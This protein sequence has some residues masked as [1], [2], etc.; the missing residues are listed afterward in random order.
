MWAAGKAIL[1]AEVA[2]EAHLGEK[3][4]HFSL[5]ALVFEPWEGVLL[6]LEFPPFAPLPGSL[7]WSGYVVGLWI[8]EVLGVPE[9]FLSSIGIQLLNLLL[10]QV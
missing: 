4:R 6:V 10:K 8:S 3:F 7:Q 2:W 9:P 5:V 1:Q